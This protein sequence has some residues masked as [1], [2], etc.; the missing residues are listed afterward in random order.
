[1]LKILVINEV[2]PQIKNRTSILFE[3]IVPILCKKNEVKIFWL[4]TDKIE[5]KGNTGFKYESLY[6]KNFKNAKEVIEKINPSLIYLFPGQSIIDYSFFYKQK[7]KE[8]FIYKH[9]EKVIKGF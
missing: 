7:L 8:Y 5:E 3:K 6:W 9:C 4:S 1:M 2:S